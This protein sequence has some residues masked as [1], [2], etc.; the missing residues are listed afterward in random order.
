VP[1][2]R[3][4]HRH[5]GVSGCSDDLIVADRPTRLDDRSNP[6]VEQDLKSVREREER[7]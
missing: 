3:Q 2:P 4:I 1:A 5:P 6:G 7:V